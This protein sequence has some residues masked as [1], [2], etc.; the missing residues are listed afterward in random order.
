M[1]ADV[2]KKLANGEKLEE[3]YK[4]HPLTGN[5]AG[6]HECHIQPDWILIYQIAEFDL[7]LILTR[8]GTR[9]DLF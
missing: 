8:T 9:S 2:I 4:D 3:K 1:L 7:I 6:R 5:Y